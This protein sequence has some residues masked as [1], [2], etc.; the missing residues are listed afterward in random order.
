MR[1]EIKYYEDMWEQIKSATM[2]TI[3][4]ESGSYPDSKWKTKLIMA[5]HS[6]IRL[7]KFIVKLYDIPTFV[8]THLVRHKNGVEQ[9]VETRRD[10]RTDYE[11]VPNRNTPVNMTME[12]NFQAILNIS[13]KRLCNCAHK[14]TIKVWEMVLEEIKKYEPELYNCCVREC[15]RCG[16]CPEFKSC[17]Y[18]HS[19]KFIEE[20]LKYRSLIL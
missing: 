1:C 12:L 2:T 19:D 15:V 9:F 5:E 10:D 16:F 13:R 14:E 7:G 18:N 4:K 20:I 17:G 8:S 6:P 3:S 11:K